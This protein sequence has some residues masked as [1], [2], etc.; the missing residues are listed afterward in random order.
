MA[1]VAWVM[2][3]S[4]AHPTVALVALRPLRVKPRFRIW[5]VMRR[6]SLAAWANLDQH[7]VVATHAPRPT[8]GWA[9]DAA[10]T[11]PSLESCTGQIAWQITSEISGPPRLGAPDSMTHST[12]CS[13]SGTAATFQRVR[14]LV[15]ILPDVLYHSCTYLANPS[16]KRQNMA[17]KKPARVGDEVNPRAETTGEPRREDSA[18]RDLASTC[19]GGA[20][21]LIDRPEVPRTYLTK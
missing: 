19:S 14:G 5:L 4:A 2:A 12:A 6:G 1:T 3:S 17:E 9:G 18:A 15:D 11:A 7:P 10:A 8:S 16:T 21:E 13:S 20:P